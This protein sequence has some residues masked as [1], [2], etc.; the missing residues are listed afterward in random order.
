VITVHARLMHEKAWIACYHNYNQYSNLTS[1]QYM[2]ERGKHDSVCMQIN[3]WMLSPRRNLQWPTRRKQ[4]KNLPAISWYVLVMI[5]SALFIAIISVVNWQE[6][7]YFSSKFFQNMSESGYL[8]FSRAWAML[9]CKDH[10]YMVSNETNVRPQV[11]LT[12]HT[13][14]I[15]IL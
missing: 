10:A 15:P 2:H 1:E 13:W 3:W 5:K 12:G 4:N 6:K 11:W 14:V 9:H 8:V 7:W